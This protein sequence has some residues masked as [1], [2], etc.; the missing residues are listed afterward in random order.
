MRSFLFLLFFPLCLS[1][2]EKPKNILLITA[3]DMNADSPGWMG[4]ALKPTPNI[5]P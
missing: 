1:A 2:A 3:D 4:N 5:V